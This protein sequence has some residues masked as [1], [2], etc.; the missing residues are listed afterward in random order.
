M[1]ISFLIIIGI[2]VV[3]NFKNA[4]NSDD[5][6]GV[7]LLFSIFNFLVGGFLLLLLNFNM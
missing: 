6:G 7:W 1:G 4:L 2:G 5:E 3:S